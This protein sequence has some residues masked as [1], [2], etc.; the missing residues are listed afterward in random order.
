MIFWIRTA[1]DVTDVVAKAVVAMWFVQMA[2]GGLVSSNHAGLACTEWPTCNGGVWFPVFDGIVGLQLAHRMGGYTLFALAVGLAVTARG[3]AARSHAWT[4]L[5]LVLFQVA[6]GVTNV[7]TALPVELAVLHSA[8][9]DLIGIA[10]AT[11][12]LRTA[13]SRLG[14]PAGATRLGL[15]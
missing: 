1:I 11:L 5:G 3:S 4:V 12:V 10:A 7:L 8:T 6:L 15:A 2:L 14:S 9:A 13:D